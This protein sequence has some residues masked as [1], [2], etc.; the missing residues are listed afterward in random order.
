MQIHTL[1]NGGGP[2]IYYDDKFRSVLEDHLSYLRNDQGTT[3]LAVKPVDIDKYRGDLYGL[4]G[5]MAIPNEYHWVVMRM[6]NIVSPHDVP[7]KLES[8]LV[9][10]YTLVERIRV[11]HVT[12]AR[13]KK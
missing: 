11:G 13:M 1:A 3:T 9:P 10:D 8:V 5:S 6:N 4:F 12:Q 7:E 2:D